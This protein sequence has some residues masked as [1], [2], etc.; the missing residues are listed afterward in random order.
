MKTFCFQAHAHFEAADGEEAALKLAEHFTWLASCFRDEP[1]ED[2]TIG[3]ASGSQISILPYA[4]QHPQE[5][6]H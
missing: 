4:H 6:M 3:L 5:V 1:K 2:S